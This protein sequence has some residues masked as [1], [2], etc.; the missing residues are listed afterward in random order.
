M[1]VT[2]RMSQYGK[3]ALRAIIPQLLMW[4]SI[5]MIALL[6]DVQ[7][8]FIIHK[9]PILVFLICGSVFLAILAAI[10]ST[11]QV[12]YLSITR[13]LAFHD[14]CSVFLVVLFVWELLANKIPVLDPMIFTCPTRV[15]QFI[16]TRFD[17]LWVNSLA[18]MYLLVLGFFIGIGVGVLLGVVIG[19]IKPVFNVIY[20]VAK[21]VA[22]IP[23][24][25]YIPFALVLFP[26]PTWGQVLIIALGAFWPTFAN[27]VF[28]VHNID[29]RTIE[30]A[31]MLGAK[32]LTILRRI[33]IPSVLPETFA[34]I[35]IGMILAFIMLTVAEM[36]GA[37]QGLGF[38]LHTQ[39][40]LN[41]YD[42]VAAIIVTVGVI[43]VIWSVVFDRVEARALRWKVRLGA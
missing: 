32:P 30:A 16:Y 37:S 3:M 35:F 34:G 18:S 8:V 29:R 21:I 33:V 15:F 22:P 9:A 4:G 41:H 36:V 40:L 24:V 43:V 38:I 2:K 10:A 27:V 5:T 7:A 12:K 31:R 28:A 11:K 42:A 17:Y 23:P 26:T 20:P 19:W 1:E 39:R 25:V 6:P 14:I 13:V